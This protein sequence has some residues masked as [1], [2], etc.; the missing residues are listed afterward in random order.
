MADA[1]FRQMKYLSDTNAQ[2]REGDVLAHLGKHDRFQVLIHS[3]WWFH[4]DM[5]LQG[6][7]HHSRRVPVSQRGPES[8]VAKAC[9]ERR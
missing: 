6:P 9:S 4:R 8:R 5:L 2:W 1:Y 7:Y 3:D